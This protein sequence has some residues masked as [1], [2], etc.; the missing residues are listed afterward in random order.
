MFKQIALGQ[1]RHL[2][3]AGAGVMVTSGYLAAEHE[4]AAIGIVM[5]LAGALWSFIDKKAR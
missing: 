5:G 2:L 1:L 4:Q 3:T